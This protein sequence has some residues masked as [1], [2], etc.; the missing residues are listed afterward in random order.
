MQK[1]KK[2]SGENPER[3]GHCIWVVNSV[4]TTGYFREG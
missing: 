1:I 2:E 4:R 3:T